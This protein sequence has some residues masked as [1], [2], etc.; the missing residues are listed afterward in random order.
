MQHIHI[1]PLFFHDYFNVSLDMKQWQVLKKPME[2][3]QNHF[4]MEIWQRKSFVVRP[5]YFLV[6]MQ[7]PITDSLVF[8]LFISVERVYLTVDN[9]S[10]EYSIYKNR[11]RVSFKYILCLVENEKMNERH[12]TTISHT[13][14]NKGGSKQECVNLEA[15]I[16]DS[17]YYQSL[18]NMEIFFFV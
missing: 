4:Q 9:V 16:F 10:C 5:T 14:E 8:C 7:P 18:K 17:T 11:E 13:A 15:F 2:V 1:S 12:V 6:I 3:S